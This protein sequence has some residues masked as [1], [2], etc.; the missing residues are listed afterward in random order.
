MPLLLVAMPFVTSSIPTSASVSGT[1]RPFISRSL[2]SSA[3]WADL[4][5]TVVPLGFFRTSDVCTVVLHAYGSQFG[6]WPLFSSGVST[7]TFRQKRLQ[8]L[9]AFFVCDSD[10]TQLPC[11]L[12]PNEIATFLSMPASFVL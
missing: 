3:F 7:Q 8:V 6:C 2:N 10:P 1:V 5:L 12:H 9:Q 4:G 11:Q